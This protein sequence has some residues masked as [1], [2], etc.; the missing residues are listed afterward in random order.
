MYV[1]WIELFAP[2]S[3]RHSYVEVLTPVT[4]NVAL[5]RVIADEIS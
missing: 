4:Q 5:W 3:R 1:L 2:L